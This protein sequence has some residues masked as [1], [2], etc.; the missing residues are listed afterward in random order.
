[1]GASTVRND[2]DER[3][4][5]AKILIGRTVE[6]GVLERLIGAVRTGESRVLVLRGAPGAGKSALLEHT[7]EAAGDLRVL[8]AV[9]IEAETELAFA[10]LHQVCAPLLGRLVRLPAPQRAALETVFGMRDGAA[11]DRFL[12]GLAVLTLLADA[13][14]ERPL[15]CVIDDGQWTDR[16]SAQVLG[17]V[18]RR[19]LAESVGLVLGTR[20][21][22]PELL[23]LPELAVTGLPDADARTLLDSVPHVRLDPHIRDR[24]VAE[25]RGNPRA[26]LDLPRGLTVTQLAAGLGLV[27]AGPPSGVAEESLLARFESLPGPARLLVLLAAAEPVGDPMLLWR[28]GEVL[29]ITA[30]L[31]AADSAQDLLSV[32]ERVTFRHPLARSAIYRAA[33]PAERRAVHRALAQVTDDQEAPD[34]RAWH[35]AGAASGPDEAV[36]TELVRSAGRVQARGGLAAAAALLQR[37][38]VLTGDSARRA[39]RAVAAADASLRAGDLQ[40]A[41]RFA[42]TADREARSA[43]ERARAERV[44]S[45][46]TFSAPRL[47]AAAQDLD[48]FDH[49]S[50]RETYL[51]AWGSAALLTGEGADL[52]AVARAINVRPGPAGVPGVVDLLLQGCALLVTGGPAAAVPVLRRALPALA[53]LPPAPGPAWGWVAG[54]LAGAVWD[55]HVMRLLGRRAVDEARDAGALGE[56]P[57]ALGC[58]GAVLVSTGDLAAAD[59]VAAEARLVAAATGVPPAP[60]LDLELSALRGRPDEAEPLLEERTD[61]AA[62]WAA[63]ILYNGLGRYEDALR[64]AGL[65]NPFTAARALP[66]LIEA[67][68]RVGDDDAARAA[69]NDL[70]DATKPCGTDWALGVL[71]RSRALLSEGAAADR[72]YREAIDRLRRTQ[73]RPDLARAHLLYGEWLRRGRRRVEARQQLRTAYEMV[74]SI[75]MEAFGERARRE[76]LATGET[77]RKRTVEA[78]SNGELTPQERQIALLVRDGFSNPEVGARLYLS[79]RTVEWHLRKVFAKL[80]ITSRRQLRAVLRG[81]DYEPALD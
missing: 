80:S 71:A 13:S 67:A 49:D 62:H 2:D 78:S 47:L 14:A 31:A 53:D 48:R 34:R 58:W 7:R 54:G 37:S 23:G 76:L 10:T 32:D 15:L 33:R 38:V 18:A 40:A 50:A 46:I 12:V 24:I 19:L 6:C 5:P 16:A 64:R 60:N 77:V 70:A 27:D 26:L 28:A 11:P 9:G 8:A 22:G 30:A 51:L 68:V 63:A 45:R 36:A 56:L 17:F 57:A 69:L 35:L 39:D 3:H 81:E 66:E 75:G 72:N 74:V 25:A 61:T 20:Q 42:H 52:T 41:R 4:H 79:P 44:G 73:L 59:G 21:P 43:R 65:V 29:G 55:E 1:M